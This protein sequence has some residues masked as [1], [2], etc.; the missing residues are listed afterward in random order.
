MLKIK[1]FRKEVYLLT[2]YSPSHIA[3]IC[4]WARRLDQHANPLNASCVQQTWLSGKVTC[5]VTENSGPPSPKETLIILEHRPS[6]EGDPVT[7]KN[8][9]M[10]QIQSNQGPV[11]SQ[12]P[13]TCC[14]LKGT[15]NSFFLK[16]ASLLPGRELR[17]VCL[18]ASLPDTSH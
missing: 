13:P 2:Y 6:S 16:P 10:S 18:A 7:L 9:F 12:W 4:H 8:H 17:G 5:L 3:G 11:G 14:D 15:G 1:R